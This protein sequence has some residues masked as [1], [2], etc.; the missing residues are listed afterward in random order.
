M[1]LSFFF[2]ILFVHITQLSYKQICFI[3]KSLVKVEINL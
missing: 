1:F 2:F 3:S